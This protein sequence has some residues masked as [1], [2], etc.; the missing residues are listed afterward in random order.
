LAVWAESF[1]LHF[2]GRAA[3]RQPVQTSRPCSLLFLFIR[4]GSAAIINSGCGGAG[5]FEVAVAHLGLQLRRCSHTI[6][7]ERSKTL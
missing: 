4:S 6:N 5:L 7:T 2:S 3:N 1:E